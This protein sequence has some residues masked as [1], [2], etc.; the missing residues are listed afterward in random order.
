VGKVMIQNRPAGGEPCGAT[1]S[2]KRA[3]AVSGTALDA[4]RHQ[5]RLAKYA[6][7]IVLAGT[8]P[9]KRHDGS[10][11]DPPALSQDEPPPESMF[12]WQARVASP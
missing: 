3:D 1:G 5:S 8:R 9:A 10:S 4:A 11:S 12:A 6:D 7:R 2:P